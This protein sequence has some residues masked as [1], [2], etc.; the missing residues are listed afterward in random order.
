MFLYTYI[1]FKQR[2]CQYHYMDTPHGRWLSAQE[3]YEPNWTNPGKNIPQNNSYTATSLSS[4]KPSILDE[5][6]MRDTA[7]EVRTV[8][9]NVL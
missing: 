7:K 3:F 6:D 5:A 4:Q 8:S 2:S 1:F 9:C